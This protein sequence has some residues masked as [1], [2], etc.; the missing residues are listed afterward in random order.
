VTRVIVMMRIAMGFVGGR[1]DV[2]GGER[3]RD[4]GSSEK[5]SAI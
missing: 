3:R 4:G 1:F 5:V 2:C